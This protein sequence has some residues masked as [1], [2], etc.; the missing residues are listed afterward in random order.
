MIHGKK[1]RVEFNRI[2]TDKYE[3][4]KIR[5]EG[6]KMDLLDVLY[7]LM[8]KDIM[9]V[10]DESWAAV[11]KEIVGWDANS[12]TMQANQATRL[13]EYGARRALVLSGG[14]TRDNVAKIKQGILNAPGNL[15]PAKQLMSELLYSDF[16]VLDRSEIGGDAAQDIFTNGFTM[17]KINNVDTLVTS[18]EN[19]CGRND[20]WTFA[21]PKYYAGFYTYKDVSM[22]ID[23]KDDIWMTFFAHE[24]IGGAVINKA[25][26]SVTRLDDRVAA[27][28]TDWTV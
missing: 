1:A 10:E 23:E 4:D 16:F 7:D 27:T 26:V 11:N 5:L 8:L 21:D 3:I 19:V 18:K 2:M 15:K 20:V 17:T 12:A 13:T 28:D 6:Y 22:V 14:I 9:D 24:T 25:G